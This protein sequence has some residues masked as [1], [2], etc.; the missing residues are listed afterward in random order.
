LITNARVKRV[1]SGQVVVYNEEGDKTFAYDLLVLC[2]G[3]SPVNALADIAKRLVKDVYVIGD[4][5]S[6]RKI[7][8]AI[9][10]AF[11]LGRVV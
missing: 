7:K 1:K 9:W 11:K 8:D 5:R 3:R 2:I 10:E 4:S 6:P